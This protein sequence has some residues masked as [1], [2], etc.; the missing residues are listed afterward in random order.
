MDAPSEDDDAENVP[1]AQLQKLLSGKK[2]VRC[3]V[4][5]KLNLNN[6]V[7]P[8]SIAY[9]AVQVS[10]FLSYFILCLLM[11]ASFTSTCKQGPPGICSAE[12]L[13]T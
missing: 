3:N 9:A 2:A 10:F 7:T 4:A 13:I 5:S 1:P 6:K 12:G 11:A 8:R